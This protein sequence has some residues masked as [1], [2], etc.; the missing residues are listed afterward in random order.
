MDSPY[1]P[2]EFMRRL[3]HVGKDTEV[4]YWALILKP[5]VIEIGDGS[6]IDDYCRLEGGMGL[7][8]G[9]Y[10]H[11]ASFASILGGGEAELGDCSGMAQGAR[12]VTGSGHPCEEHFPLRMLEGDPYHRMRGRNVLG[13]Y[14][15]IAANAVVM[16]NVTVGEG[17]VVAAGAVATKDVPPWTVVAGV[18]ARVIGERKKPK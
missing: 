3:A 10:V 13:P 6:R 1:K 11:I 4:F 12:V 5:E 8:I 14:S 18:P 9:R 7:K 16:P 17:A 15:F 2:A